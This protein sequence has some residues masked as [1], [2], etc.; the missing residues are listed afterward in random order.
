MVVLWVLSSADRIGACR[1][2][3]A[4]EVVL[5]MFPELVVMEAVDPPPAVALAAV[6]LILPVI[7]VV[8]L[9]SPVATL[10]FLLW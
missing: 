8:L 3:L 4:I 7:V 10:A 1:F 9:F 2:A 5:V 6:G